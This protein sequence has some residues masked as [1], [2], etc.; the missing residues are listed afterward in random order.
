MDY[1]CHGS[2]MMVS[3]YRDGHCYRANVTLSGR[4]RHI[5][6]LFKTLTGPTKATPEMLARL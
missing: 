6:G 2:I 5:R 3:A 1:R 4:L